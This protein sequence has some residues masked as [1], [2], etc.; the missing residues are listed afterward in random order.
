MTDNEFDLFVSKLFNKFNKRESIST[1]LFHLFNAQNREKKHE[2]LSTTKNIISSIL[3]LR[4]TKSCSLQVKNNKKTPS[5]R[6]IIHVPSE[7]IGFCASYLNFND[8]HS[9]Q[10]C[11]RQIY[12]RCN[13]ANT[14]KCA[15]YYGN[16]QYT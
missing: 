16:K 4:G 15:Y 8:Y 10:R 11:S 13:D 14:L 5:K 2:K 9:F 12:I 7:I 1:S 6:L 3:K